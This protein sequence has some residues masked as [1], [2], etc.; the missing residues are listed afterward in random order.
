MG[1]PLREL[2]VHTPA[3]RF[4][5]ATMG[6]GPLVLL[7]HGFPE[8]WFSWRPQIE[9]LAARGYR[10]VAPDLPGYGATERPSDGYDV[11]ELA[12]H[13]IALVP[14]LGAEQATIIGHDWG[15]LLTWELVSRYP[16]RVAR[17]GVLNAP[18]PKVIYQTFLRSGE[19][20][21]RS[22]YAVAFNLPWLPER[23]FTLGRGALVGWML[24][25]AATDRS[26][27]TDEALAPYRD[28]ALAPGTMSAML[29]YYRTAMRTALGPG[30]AAR[31]RSYS[32]IE[33][34]G[35]LVWGE[36]EF[37]FVPEI[38]PAHLRYAR[39][40]RVRP[41]AGCGHFVHIE[42]PEVVSAILGEWLGDARP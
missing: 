26:R 33:R 24:R 38:V 3:L 9:A 27:F 41:I 7:L 13:L 4:H 39:D 10:V 22:W 28:A 1:D 32:P 30:G 15:G 19:Q 36:D 12:A 17:F 37:A 34:P 5:C 31:F 11:R 6:S 21:R 40:L 2:T 16:E 8:R 42:Q 29:A 23:A 18:H 35:L 20:R 25:T 14:A